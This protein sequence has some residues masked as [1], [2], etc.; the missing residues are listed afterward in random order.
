MSRI[1]ITTHTEFR[2]GR[3][4]GNEV[5]IDID[6][7][8]KEDRRN[9]ELWTKAYPDAVRPTPLPERHQPK[10]ELRTDV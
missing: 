4:V 5:F 6:E 2:V 3:R 9:L 8:S 1:I 7:L 10:S